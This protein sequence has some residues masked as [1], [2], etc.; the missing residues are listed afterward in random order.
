MSDR[1]RRR[2]RGEG[3]KEKERERRDDS[4]KGNSR[5]GEKRMTVGRGDRG[6]KLKRG[7]K[8]GAL[9]RRESERMCYIEWVL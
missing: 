4:G 8:R 1:K 9:W 6:N 5:D 3:V 7:G 2:E